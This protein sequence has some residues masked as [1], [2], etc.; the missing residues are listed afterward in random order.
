MNYYKI[1]LIDRD[2]PLKEFKRN[3]GRIKDSMD[4]FEGG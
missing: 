1:D 3:R 2:N 4:E